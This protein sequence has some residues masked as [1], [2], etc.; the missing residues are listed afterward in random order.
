MIMT[1]QLNNPFTEEKIAGI[2]GRY[3]HK[4]HAHQEAFETFTQPVSLESRVLEIGVG[5]CAFT[6]LLLSAGYDVK[7]IDRSEEMLRRASEQVRGLSEKCDLLDYGLSQHYGVVVS[8]SGGFT[9]KREKFETYYQQEEDLEQ[10]IQRVYL[11]LGDK[12]RFFVNKGEHEAEIDL[13]DG[14]TFLIEQEDREKSR[15]YT[16]AFKQGSKEITKQQ[17]RLAL[18]S[19]ELQKMSSR[20][21]NWDFD[22]E[23]WIIGERI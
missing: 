16:Y 14:A 5:T 6:E 7:C 20:H 17:R 15:I 9:F 21:F 18:A 13:G 22:N 2:Y 8:H 12:G 10:A 4:Y 11:V 19:E 23:R 1:H 3:S